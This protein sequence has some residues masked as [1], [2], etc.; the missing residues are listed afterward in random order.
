MTWQSK[1]DNVMRGLTKAFGETVT[2]TPID[3]EIPGTSFEVPGIFNETYIE[4]DANEGLEII[5]RK[6]NLGVR[7]ADFSGQSNPK[8]GDRI[9]IRGTDY[10][11]ESVRD[12]GEAGSLLLL[13]KE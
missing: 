1:A 7:L 2:Y 12:D 9:S 5:T 8:N 6:P 4:V 13:D 10:L 3:D 11:V